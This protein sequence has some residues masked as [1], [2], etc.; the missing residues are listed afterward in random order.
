MDIFKNITHHG[1]QNLENFNTRKKNCKWISRILETKKKLYE[2]SILEKKLLSEIHALILKIQF[3][4]I[5]FN[6]IP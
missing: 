4:Q 1:W 2:F 6:I 3:L 5:I